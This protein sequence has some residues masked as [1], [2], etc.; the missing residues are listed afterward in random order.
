MIELTD[1]DSYNWYLKSD[2]TMPQLYMYIVIKHKKQEKKF[3][4]FKP[5]SIFISLCF[6][7]NFGWCHSINNK[8]KMR[9]RGE[10]NGMAWINKNKIKS[11][12]LR[13]GYCRSFF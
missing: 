5:N 8:Q 1:I 13:W 9:K 3:K 4:L 10:K 2:R 6:S 7:E 11:K 12:C